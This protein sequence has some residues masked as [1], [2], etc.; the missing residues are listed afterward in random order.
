MDEYIFIDF[1]MDVNCD[2]NP[3]QIIG[4]GAIKTDKDG[5][6]IDSYESYNKL[7]DKPFLY[8]YTTFLT[9]IKD[10]N[11]KKSIS[12]SENLINLE[13]FINS[14]KNIYCWGD[15]DLKC[16]KKTSYINNIKSEF[17]ENNLKDFRNFLP[18]KHKK[19]YWEKLFNIAK[20][21]DIIAKD[22]NQKH[23]SIEDAIILKEIFFKMK[24]D[25]K[26]G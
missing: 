12:F 16:L 17:I 14:N 1:E 5:N 9:G 26:N 23:N 20:E 4:I 25:E 22:K 8:K 3:E 19:Y 2:N 18:K 21:F 10:S 15:C 6:I 7:K 13:N 24:E 11:V